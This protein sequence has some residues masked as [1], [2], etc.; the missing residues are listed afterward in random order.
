MIYAYGET[1]IAITG[2][3]TIDGQGSNDNWWPWNGNPKF[4][5]KPGIPS[6][7][8]EAVIDCKCI[9]KELFL[10]QNVYFL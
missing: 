10:W 6:Q 9:Q 4:G 7:K 8:V 5:W 1:N 3:G 2:Y